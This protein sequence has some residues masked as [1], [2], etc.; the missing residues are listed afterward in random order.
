MSDI[1]VLLSETRTFAPPARLGPPAGTRPDE[2]GEALGAELL[3][4]GGSGPR[5]RA[6]DPLLVAPAELGRLWLAAEECVDR[7]GDI[8]VDGDPV[9]VQWCR[10][11]G[12]DR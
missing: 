3:P 7:L 6:M 11:T 10:E 9:A 12:C 4:G 1:D 8:G 2:A 5:L